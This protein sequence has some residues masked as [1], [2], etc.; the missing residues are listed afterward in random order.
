MS[1][2]VWTELKHASLTSAGRSAS[3]TRRIWKHLEKI[4]RLSAP[5]VFDCET[6]ASISTEQLQLI[7]NEIARTL[8][9]NIRKATDLLATGLYRGKRLHGWQVIVPDHFH[10]L[11]K[12]RNLFTPETL[13]SSQPFHQ[14]R[15]T[16]L[17]SLVDPWDQLDAVSAEKLP[18]LRAGRILIS[19]IL[20]G[21]LLQHKWLKPWLVALAK[22]PVL[23]GDWMWLEMNSIPN[24]RTKSS[25]TQ[26]HITSW[27][28]F[29]R[30]VAD[31]LTQLLILNWLDRFPEDH[32]LLG[33]WDPSTLV[34]DALKHLGIHC[35]QGRRHLTALIECATAYDAIIQPGFLVAY[36]NGQ[37]GSASLPQ[38]AFARLMTGE[39]PA[40]AIPGPS[41]EKPRRGQ[42]ASAASRILS[43]DLDY[44][45]RALNLVL[46][47]L[48]RSNQKS[49]Q[50]EQSRS[51]TKFKLT[52]AQAHDRIDTFLKQQT[53]KLTPA[54]ELLL[55]WGCSLFKQSQSPF[56]KRKG[57]PLAVSTVATYLSLIAEEM[58]FHPQLPDFSKLRE[59]DFELLYEDL[60][61]LEASS[62]TKARIVARLEQFH[63]FLRAND[64]KIAN[65]DFDEIKCCYG[66]PTKSVR[67]NLITFPEYRAI[68]KSFGF[69]RKHLSRWQR[70]Y[71]TCII[72]AFRCGLRR[73]ELQGLQIRD[74][75]NRIR[76]ELR[77]RPGRYRDLK[78]AAANRRLPLYA[79]LTEKELNLVLEW[80]ELRRQEA[81][82]W[83]SPLFSHPD[84]KEELIPLTQLIAPIV[85]IMR[86]V[87]RDGTLSMHSFRHAA[88]NWIFLR[89]VWRTDLAINQLPAGMQ[90]ETFTPANLQRLKEALLENQA[91]GTRSL[92]AVC[93][94]L[95]HGDVPTS[96][97]S[98][99]HTVDFLQGAFKR[100]SFCLPHLPADSWRTVCQLDDAETER[101]KYPQARPAYIF[102]GMLSRCAER[103]GQP[104]ELDRSDGSKPLVFPPDYCTGENYWLPSW[105]EALRR[106]DRD[107]GIRSRTKLTIPD[108]EEFA[109][110]ERI[111]QNIRELTG[112]E[113]IFAR[114]VIPMLAN[115]YAQHEGGVIT[116]S[117]IIAKEYGQLLG[118]L[119][120]DKASVVLGHHPNAKQN[121]EHNKR[122]LR[123]WQ[124]QLGILPSH[125]YQG[126]PV[127]KG[128]GPK[129]LVV[130]KLCKHKKKGNDSTGRSSC[131]EARHGFRFS[132]FLI[133]AL[134]ACSD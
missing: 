62:D 100:H 110:A 37:L 12:E 121:L 22:G 101:L 7:E 117:H 106:L 127:S 42:K 57:K 78:S 48:R 92:Y 47:Y 85:E 70:I 53:G 61:A 41:L 9:K 17:A 18:Q 95:G 126:R 26:S 122:H 4:L 36:Q 123:K 66:L 59:V 56:E 13:K 114:R 23:H 29:R 2:S 96:F 52:K 50:P 130:L 103:F 79:L 80:V 58:I 15:K 82:S 107:D 93:T 115:L 89:L 45:F 38:H 46:K 84:V 33:T 32:K 116:D 109:L 76:A 74:V 133:S 97:T 112:R 16:L 25:Y 77:V 14:I 69:G 43:F 81:R 40:K 60:L 68:L 111:Y 8:P 3:T 27:N 125:S 65:V 28:L 128:C 71:L 31:P 19:A 105:G 87:T 113:M 67:A 75:K 120:L 91:Q 21:G 124:E 55:R 134:C 102:K 118:Y 1:V 98:Y 64:P 119:N 51:T 30:W 11:P 10:A 99:I 6:G 39:I 35:F 88:A 86:K 63:G 108:T 49:K 129:G 132:L 90:D 44:S 72:L 131:Y 20:H 54:T 83:Q 24:Q 104:W 34:T 94:L 5:K 73:G